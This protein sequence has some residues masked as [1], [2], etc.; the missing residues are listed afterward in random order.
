MNL[1]AMIWTPGATPTT[2]DA[3]QRRRDGAR[4]RASRARPG[5]ASWTRRVVV[6]EVPAVD[7]VDEAVPVVVDA[8]RPRSRRGSSMPRPRDPGWLKSMPSSMTATTIDGSPRV[9]RSAS[10]PSMSTSAMPVCSPC[11]VQAS[12]RCC[13]D[14]TRSRSPAR[15]VTR[16]RARGGGSAR[17]RR[18]PGRRRGGDGRWRSTRPSADDDLGSAVRRWSTRRPG[19]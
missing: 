6:A 16:R 7:V 12:G 18:P 15:S 17:P 19:R 4:P 10:R 14:P 3:V 9:I 2:P 8:V 1:T 5:L 13:G 11:A